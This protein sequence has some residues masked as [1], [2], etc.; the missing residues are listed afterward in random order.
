MRDN[1]V[2]L[3][4]VNYRLGPFGFL[5]LSALGDTSL[6]RSRNLGLLDQLAA[7][8]WVRANI[9]AFGGDTANVTVF[10]ESAGGSAVM[11][12][13]AMPLA[14]GLFDKAIIESGG[15]ANIRVRGVPAAAPVDGGR[16]LAR[17]FLAESHVPGLAGLMALH[18]DSVLAVATRVAHARGDALGVSTWGARA[19]DVVLPSDLFGDVRR[20]GE[21]AGE[22]PDRHQRG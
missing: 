9:G 7:L 20:G 11:R 19:D 22:G 18:G 5:D 16:A 21:P 10:G 3:V 12:L 14:R 17:E 4:S 15:P 2:V 13:V 8:R 6:A 1:D